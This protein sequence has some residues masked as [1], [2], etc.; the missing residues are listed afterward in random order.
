MS[1]FTVSLVVCLTFTML[2]CGGGSDKYKK[3]RLKTVKASGT[4]IYRNQPLADAIV[5]CFPTAAGDKAVAASA[6]TDGDGNFTLQAYPPAKG[7]VPGDYQVTI[8]KTEP[9]TETPAAS[10]AAA[11]DAPPPPEPR[12]LIPVKYSKVE[13]SDLRLTVPEAGV[14]DVKFELKD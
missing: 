7:A 6:Y 5:V 14:S 3:A 11:H 12:P 4:V 10:S 9:A 8:Q 13:T 2:G 1:R